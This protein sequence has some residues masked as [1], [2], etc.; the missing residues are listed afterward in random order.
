MLLAERILLLARDLSGEPLNSSQKGRD[1]ARWL[2]VA[3]VTELAALALFVLAAPARAHA[4]EKV[5]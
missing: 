4:T 5:T 1:L 2:G 3:V